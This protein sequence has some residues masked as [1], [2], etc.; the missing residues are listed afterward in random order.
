LPDDRKDK[1]GK[2]IL[3]T[4]YIAIKKK[5][6]DGTLVARSEEDQFKVAVSPETN[7]SGG[8]LH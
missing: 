6:T 5:G 1:K 4:L 7:L 8:M 3:N 2:L